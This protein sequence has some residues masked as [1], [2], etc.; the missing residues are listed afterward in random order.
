MNALLHFHSGWRWIVLIL[1]VYSVFNAFSK[2]RF[3]KDYSGFDR[4]INL[5]TMISFHVQFLVGLILYFWSPKVQFVSG[6]MKEPMLRFYTVEHFA[7]MTIAMIV[8]TIGR[9][10]AEKSGSV[11][12]THRRYWIWY[13]AALLI[14][15][16][17]IPWPFRGLGGNW[18]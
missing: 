5:F 12:A 11:A 1:L 13:G 9:K 6:V 4:M 10:R 2:W 16:I 7:M 3:A 8:I 14:V 17:S 15:L 18:F